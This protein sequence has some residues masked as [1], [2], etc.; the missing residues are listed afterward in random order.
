MRKLQNFL[1]SMIGLLLFGMVMWVSQREALLGYT[2][3]VAL[4]AISVF[5]IIE[6]VGP[7]E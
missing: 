6:R 2:L 7:K 3:G 4:I 5:V 1:L